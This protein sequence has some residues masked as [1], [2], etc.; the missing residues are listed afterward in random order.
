MKIMRPIRKDDYEA[1]N[2]IA[3]ESGVG[4]TS[5]PVDETLLKGKIDRAVASFSKEVEKPD[6]EH[7]L[8]VMEDTETGEVVGTAGIEAAVGIDD[9]FYSY[10]HGKVVHS[11]RELGVHN[12]VETLTLCNDYTGMSE[13]CTLFL[14]EVAREGHNG[15]FLSRFRFLFLA[16]HRERFTEKVF[17]EM[18]GVSDENGSSPFWKWLEE[19][20][21]SLDFPTADYLTG[22]GQKVFIAEL[23][24]KYPIYV[25]LLSKEAQAVIGEVHERTRPALK[26]LLSE[27]FTYSGYVDIFDAGPSI[28]AD[29]DNIRTVRLSRRLPVSI[30]S[31]I[32]E[33]RPE[34]FAI[35]TKLEDFRAAMLN[36]KVDEENQIVRINDKTA[37]AL[38]VEDGEFIRFAPIVSGD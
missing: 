2:R 32:T 13:I 38:K 17:A 5:L 10:H 28:E 1:L 19:H 20:F 27:G 3:V 8:F 35:N 14:R 31:T 16:E 7:Y 6:S 24:P 34:Y 33:D 29:I 18:R 37:S 4:F 12:E 26:L 36:L 22:V 23:M 11:S 30:D 15:R 21:F 25:N 9:V